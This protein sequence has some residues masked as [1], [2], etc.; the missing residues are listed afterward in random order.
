MFNI[1]N[2]LFTRIQYNYEI[3]STKAIMNNA[4]RLLLANII[5]FC[6]IQSLY[7]LFISELL[8]IRTKLNT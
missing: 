8:N 2:A 7:K 3:K 5:L 6:F 1:Q 4:I